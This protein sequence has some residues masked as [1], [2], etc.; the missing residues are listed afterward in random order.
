MRLCAPSRCKKR[1]RE[2]A[3]CGGNLQKPQSQSR[4]ASLEQ[5]L[6]TA[7]ARKS[8][9]WQKKRRTSAT[10]MTL[11]SQQS[12]S[13][14]SS[15]SV[16]SPPEQSRLYAAAPRK[17]RIKKICIIKAPT[18]FLHMCAAKTNTKVTRDSKRQ[19]GRCLLRPGDHKLCAG[20]RRWRAARNVQSGAEKGSLTELDFISE[21]QS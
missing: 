5:L 20:L 11:C 19:T 4:S 8:L 7:S 17:E 10:L 13:S 9:K 14:D 15:C 1:R 18:L 12:E 3:S 16:A 21:L 2:V 6:R